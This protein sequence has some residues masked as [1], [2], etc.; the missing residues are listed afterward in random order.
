MLPQPSWWEYDEEAEEYVDTSDETWEI[1][2][3]DAGTESDVNTFYVSNNHPEATE[4]ETDE[5]VPHMYNC[6][7]TVVDGDGG[8]EMALV[9]GKDSEGED[10]GDGDPWTNISV[11][12]GE[13]WTV[14]G[15]DE[16]SQPIGYDQELEAGDE[17][18]DAAISGDYYSGEDFFEE[19][20]NYNFTDFD[21][22]LD[23]PEEAPSGPMDF[24][25]RI[26]YDYVGLGEEE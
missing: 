10:I 21:L 12:G 25:L 23:V 20:D 13:E 19:E 17:L 3:V 26:T 2:I 1:G 18:V 16:Q 22:M 14:V 8:E 4:A 9:T 5:D 11:D 7:F 6:S 24:L 15:G